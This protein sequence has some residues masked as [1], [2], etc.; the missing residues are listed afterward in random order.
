MYGPLVAILR[1]FGIPVIG[2]ECVSSAS[3][4]HLRKVANGILCLGEARLCCFERPLVRFVFILFQHWFCADHVPGAE[5]HLRGRMAVFGSASV[6]MNSQCWISRTVQ[7][8]V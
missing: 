1:R 8:S 4:A 7:F 2:G 5:S 6:E 3:N